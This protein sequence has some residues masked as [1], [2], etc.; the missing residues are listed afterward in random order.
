MD[1]TKI[2]LPEENKIIEKKL[3]SP[4][5][6]QLLS[7]SLTDDN[8]M[9]VFL[10]RAVQTSTDDKLFI[11]VP[12]LISDQT[13]VSYI[14]TNKMFI[15]NITIFDDKKDEYTDLIKDMNE[16]NTYL[17]DLCINEYAESKKYY[18]LKCT[19]NCDSENGY[20]SEIDLLV[21]R[22][23]FIQINLFINQFLLKIL[24]ADLNFLSYK[25]KNIEFITIDHVKLDAS[26]EDRALKSVFNHYTVG[27][28]PTIFKFNFLSPISEDKNKRL[29]NPMIA[30]QYEIFYQ[31]DF[32]VNDLI[33]DDND[34]LLL[35]FEERSEI[36]NNYKS[37]K[38]LR[39][40]KDMIEKTN[41]VDLYKVYE[42]KFTIV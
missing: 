39:F 34:D 14:T 38:A 18:I 24:G 2:T 15:R 19:R 12:F 32:I 5:E 22:D 11:Q 21:S 23:L 7:I 37:T 16:E 28:G 6:F 4:N 20:F 36:N 41:L 40:N 26:V 17:S 35:L 33:R 3:F 29:R 31:N 9:G 42:D 30:S 25:Y 27:C 1:L 8:N 13:D 10:F